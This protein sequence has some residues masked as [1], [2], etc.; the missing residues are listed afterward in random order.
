MYNAHASTRLHEA[1]RPGR[2]LQG[3]SSTAHPA[4]PQPQSCI[5]AATTCASASGSRSAPSSRQRQQPDLPPSPRRLQHPT[6]PAGAAKLAARQKRRR[7]T[8]HTPRASR[9]PRV[10][11]T[12]GSR[13]ACGCG[14]RRRRT[15]PARTRI[16]TLRA[17]VRRKTEGVRG[18]TLPSP[19]SHPLHCVP[20]EPKSDASTATP[21]AETTR[22]ASRETCAVLATG[23][24][25]GTDTDTEAHQCARARPW[26]DSTLDHNHNPGPD[27]MQAPARKSTPAEDSGSMRRAPPAH[28]LDA[29]TRARRA[30]PPRGASSESGSS[31]PAHTH[32]GLGEAG[33]G[34]YGAH[35][36]RRRSPSPKHSA[37]APSANSAPKARTRAGGCRRRP[38][39]GTSTC[40]SAK[41]EFRA[42]GTRAGRRP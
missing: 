34:G 35:N 27:P 28:T 42:Q 21:H 5:R 12:P 11:R 3:Q 8:S 9:R 38:K 4:L 24:D 30:P 39:N 6:P 25:T 19:P 2:R 7:A 40:G 41:V 10:H 1:T 22:G 13:Q 29:R 18:T 16:R 31:R 33:R 32:A 26:I 17:P 15:A 20:P 37:A 23:A 14:V 36:P